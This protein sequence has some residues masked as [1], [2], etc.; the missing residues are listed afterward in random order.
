[1]EK[2]FTI[3]V[4]DLQKDIVDLINKA[5]MP[6]YVLKNILLEIIKM[7]EDTD[8]AEITNYFEEIHK[9]EQN[10]NMQ[11]NQKD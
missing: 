8:G 5:N 2:P 9:G 11:E 10:G 4:N 3:K 1:M 7:I 6:C